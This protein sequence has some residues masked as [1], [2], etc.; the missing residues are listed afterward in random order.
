MGSKGEERCSN[1]SDFGAWVTEETEVKRKS[2]LREKAEEI[3]L[4]PYPG[5][6]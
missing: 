1:D 2:E 3:R 4:G 5:E 6:R